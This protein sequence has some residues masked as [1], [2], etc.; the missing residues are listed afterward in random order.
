MSA[1][2]NWTLHFSWGCTGGYS[3][4]PMT[5]NANGT[6]ALAPY[7]GKYTEN[8]GKIIFKFDTSNTVYGGDIVSN[9]MLGISSTFGGLTGCWYAL[10]V[11]TTALEVDA[12]TGTDAAGNK[13]K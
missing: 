3:T 6:F 10:R 9:D 7:T 11:G 2:G 13:P 8:D 1:V 5:F 4:S 12:K